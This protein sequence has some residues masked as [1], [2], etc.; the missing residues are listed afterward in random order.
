M[1]ANLEK[2]YE[3]I[4]FLLKYLYRFPAMQKE[5]LDQILYFLKPDYIERQEKEA[6]SKLTALDQDCERSWNDF[7]RELKAFV[8]CRYINSYPSA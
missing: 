5:T 7:F 8:K 4:N 6:D 1:A 2:K 3:E